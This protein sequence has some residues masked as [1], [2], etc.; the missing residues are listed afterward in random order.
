MSMNKYNKQKGFTLVELLISMFIFSI[1]LGGAANLVFSSAASQ[2]RILVIQQ[3]VSQSSYLQEYMSRAIRQAKKELGSPATCLTGVGPGYNYELTHSGQGILFID[4]QNRCHEF[5]VQGGRIVEDI[6][7]VEQFITPDELVVNELNFALIGES[8]D[9]NLQP[10]VT[11]LLDIG[12]TGGKADSTLD[13]QT[14][15]TVS[16]RNVDILQ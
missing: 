11:F 1:I 4:R 10:R 3:L 14:Q 13:I 7:G 5:F 8:Q 6:G 2:R 9:D 16:Q 12:K 15:T